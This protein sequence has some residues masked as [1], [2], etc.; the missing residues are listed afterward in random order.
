MPH[1]TKPT[2]RP[3]LKTNTVYT[4]TMHTCL[5]T[6]NLPWDHPWRQTLS[7]LPQCT[8]ASLHKTYPQ[9]T[10]EDK[11]CLHSH[12][13]HMPHYTKP[14]LRLPLKTNTAYTPTMHTCLTTQNLPWDHPWRQT[15]STLPQCTHA[16]LQKTYPETTP[17]DKHC[18]HSHN[19]HMPHYTKPTLR[20]PLKTNTVYTPTMNTCL[21]TQNLP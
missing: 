6:K 11:H 9:T 16:S 1:Y 12:N 19:A 14:T 20:P 21:T 17:E 18:L 3:P 7:T 4:P 13:E 2:L 15:L 8:H 5:T 10:P